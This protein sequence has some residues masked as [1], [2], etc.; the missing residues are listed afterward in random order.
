MTIRHAIFLVLICLTLLAMPL[1]FLID[2]TSENI[3]SAA[4][5]MLS[6]IIVL[7]YL[8]WS[9]ALDTTPL[10]AFS[11]FGLCVTML[12]GALLVQTA[13]WTPLRSSLYD[14]LG[15][16]SA[17][18]FYQGIALLA[19][20][21]YRYFSSAARGEATASNGVFRRLLESLGIY[22]IPPAKALWFMGVIGFVFGLF[23]SRFDGIL[24]RVA[25][26]ANF[27]AWA[28]FLI[29]LY[30][31]EVGDSYCNAKTNQI[32]LGIYAVLI[33][34]L[35]LAINA[36]GIMF[37][38]VVTVFL[39]YLLVGM[40]SRALLT[41][42]MFL[43]LGGIGVLGLLLAGP[44][45]S[46]TTSM[47]IARQWRG[48]VSTVEMIGTTLDVW[49]R[50]KLIEAFIRE[51]DAG[52]PQYTA[53]DEHYIANP[54]L[55]RF[56]ATKFVDNSLHFAAGISTEDART[57]MREMTVNFLW[58][59]LPG[60]VLR[61]LHINVDKDDL[62]FSMGDYLGYLSRG[63]PLGA[64]KV[65]S[66]FAQGT[67][68]LGPL[69]PFVYAGICLVFFALMELLTI[70]KAHGVATITTLAMLEIWQY[71]S[72]GLSYEAFHYVTNFVVRNFAQMAIIYA[73]TY[74]V[75]RLLARNKPPLVAG[76]AWA[77]HP[78]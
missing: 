51:R 55:A 15:T 64:H 77:T 27:L 75:A 74:G 48:R 47:A 58:A 19:L 10:Q 25:A 34:I 38:G 41:R 68:T 36:R 24:A 7:V 17:L 31:L 52:G 42:Q 21:T 70:R 59:A 20:I 2:P 8:A 9:S 12:L 73:F 50:P 16:F 63:L 35:G 23:L 69:F 32:L 14:P 54:M 33:G 4:I 78:P 57:R 60:P 53:Y 26:G 29:P 72:S 1:Q 45:S 67:V 28:P 49:R 37:V 46:L 76:H 61:I 13:A 11:L 62:G 5:V 71:F 39:L 56:V 66:M 43:R 18:A 40:R 44:M 3:A 30:L 6:S 22:Q 65:G